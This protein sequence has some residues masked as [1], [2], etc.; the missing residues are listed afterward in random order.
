MRKRGLGQV[1]KRQ[2]QEMENYSWKGGIQEM[3]A[4]EST[5]IIKRQQYDK[6]KRNRPWEIQE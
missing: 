1:S 5:I 6:I 3:E 2:S 4:Q